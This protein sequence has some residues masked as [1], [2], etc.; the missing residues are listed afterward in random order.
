M[1]KKIMLA[2]MAIAAF[3]ALVV[4]PAASAATLT[5]GGS[6]LATGTSITGKNI[7]NTLFT[8]GELTVTCSSADIPGTLTTN[9]GGA[10]AGEIAAGA[11]SFTGTGTSSDCTSPLGSVKPTVNSKLCLSVAKGTDA[12][13]VDGCKNA[14]GVVQPITFTLNVTNI[15]SCKYETTGTP[16]QIAGTITTTPADAAVTLVEQP[17]TREAGQNTL[18][19]PESGALDM[20]FELT[21]TG[22]GTLTFS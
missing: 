2:C 20:E 21:T 7:G 1:H 12:G 13:T 16:P 19:C 11:P 5:D 14:S 9:S 17:A 4:V 18:F 8:A 3:A 15:V 22:G 10:V 6:A